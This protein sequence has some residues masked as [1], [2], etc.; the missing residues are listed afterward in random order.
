MKTGATNK[1]VRELINLVKEEK[2]I[3]RPEFQRRLVWTQK[4]KDRFLDTVLKGLPFPEIYLADGEVDLESGEGS[5]LLVDGLQRI[6]TLIQYFEGS[7][8]LRVQ[9]VPP[10]NALSNDE[11]RD[12]L[13]Y[14]VAV[15]DLGTVTRDMIVDV[16]QRI[17]A[18]KYSLNDIEINNAVYD[19]ALKHYAAEVG[20]GEFFKI[21]AVFNSTDYKRM[22]DLRFALSVV[23]TY[24][25][26]YFNRDD[27]FED[28]LNRYNDDFPVKGE[29]DQRLGRVL[30]FIEEC[31]FANNSRVWKKAD[32]FTLLV[33]LDLILNHHKVDVQPS[34]AVEALGKFYKEVDQSLPD[35]SNIHGV[36][37][38][39]ALQASN[40]RLNRVRRGIIVGGILQNVRYDEI[41]D[42]LF[43]ERLLP[44]TEHL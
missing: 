35:S 7:S 3:P 8:E 38:K 43:R 11:K 13:Q 41:S 23:G 26:G 17:N 44:Q 24:I 39:A 18:T 28:L 19:G 25:T 32:L 6:S 30:A 33:E 16:F 2:I 5:Q 31:G 9:T 27:A 22:G 1:R 36:Y 15:R 10:Y 14:E 12:Y 37:Y 42:E 20:E 29:I 4:D 40:D 21:N 34:F